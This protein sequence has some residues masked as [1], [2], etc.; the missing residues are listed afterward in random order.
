MTTVVA[1]LLGALASLSLRRSRRERVRSSWSTSVEEEDRRSGR[2]SSRTA[3]R[4][5]VS[6]LAE[7]RMHSAP[8]ASLGCAAV[9]PLVKLRADLAIL[10]SDHLCV[11]GTA[12]GQGVLRQGE[13]TSSLQALQPATAQLGRLVLRDRRLLRGLLAQARRTALGPL[14]RHAAFARA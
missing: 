10:I 13:S 14:I 2:L 1:M 6:Y 9:L 8:T 7:A 12:L 11:D 4:P 3:S 5:R